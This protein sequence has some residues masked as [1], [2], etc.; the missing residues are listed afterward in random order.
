MNGD[1]LTPAGDRHVG[2]DLK[3]WGVAAARL[4]TPRAPT[5]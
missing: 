3:P 4:F 2:V 5:G 1:P